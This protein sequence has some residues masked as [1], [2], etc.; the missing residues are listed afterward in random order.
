MEAYYIDTSVDVHDV[1]YNGI[2]KTSSILRYVQTAAQCQLTDGGMSYD[3]L[4]MQKRAFILSRLKMEITQPLR[5]YAPLRAITY[6]CESY[7]YSF[8]R[9]YALESE[10]VTVARA[11]S[12]W[13]LIDTEARSLVKVSDFDLNLPI[14][15][16]NDLVL[17]RFRL[18]SALTDV[19]G[20]G[21]H[22][23]D[24]D[25]NRHMN[26][27]KYPDM[28]SNFLPLEGKMISSITINYQNEAKIGEKMRVLRAE[29]NGFYYFRTVRS[30]GLVNAEAEIKLTSI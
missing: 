16:Q 5:A 20:Y 4:K 22:Y 8:L 10:G 13:A 7:G 24:V 17:N 18:P 25:Q 30:D 1:D 3:Q 15:P 23:G 6:P 28:F 2:A 14:L 19:G 26:N 27:T 11:I 21:V 29:E 9:C 12:V